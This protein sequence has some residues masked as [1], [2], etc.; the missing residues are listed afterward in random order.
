MPKSEVTAPRKTLS[1]RVLRGSLR[2][3][4]WTVVVWVALEAALQLGIYVLAQR[5]MRSAVAGTQTVLCIGDSFTF[6]IKVPDEEKYPAI[7]ERLLNAGST[8]PKYRVINVGRPGKSSGFVLAS[9]DKWIR[10]YRPRVVVIMTGWNCNDSDFAEYR[11]QSGRGAGLTRVKL[12]LFLNR[13]AT[14]RLAK[15]LVARFESVPTESVYRRVISMELY[16]FQDYQRVGLGNL[17]KICERL[18]QRGVPL[19]LLTYPEARPP[20]NPYSATEYYHYIFGKSPIGEADYLLKERHGK[21]AINAIIEYV[22]H[23]YSVPL[24][25]NAEAFRGRREADVFLVGD[26]HPN[27]AGNRIVAETV[28]ATLVRAGLLAD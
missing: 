24:A 16:D 17:T 9:L 2:L 6:G 23:G 22:A 15:Y 25:D 7:L 3:G 5:N 19:V 12:A 28:L 14:Y 11:V 13:F 26:H 27:A 8:D 4:L 10:R 21:I 1:T 18:K 20:A